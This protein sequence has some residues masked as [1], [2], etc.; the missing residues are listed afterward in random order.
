LRRSLL[1]LLILVASFVIAQDASDAPTCRIS[2][3]V[4]DSL[5]EQPLAGS[6]VTLRG[7]TQSSGSNW[8]SL[9]V[10]ADAEGHFA[11]DSL[12]PGRY[13]ITAFHTGYVNMGPGRA[14]AR[15]RAANLT[16]PGQSIDD[17]AVA[18]TP[19]G[20]ISGRLTN[21][22]NKALNQ[23]TVQVLRHEYISGHID[24]GEVSS[25]QTSKS[26]EYRIASLSPGRYFLR[27]L[28][29]DP[30]PQK[31]GSDDAYVP[32]YYPGT[33]DQSQAVALT[34]RPGEELGGMDM[35]LTP[36]H[37][38][39]VKGVVLDAAAKTPYSDGEVNL[40]PKEGAIFPSPYHATTDAKGRFAIPGVPAGEYIATAQIE[41]EGSQAT[42]KFGQKPVR[43]GDAALDGIEI[44]VAR[45]V[46][47]SGHIRVEGKTVVDLTQ[48]TG[49]IDTTENWA[50]EFGGEIDEAHI[51]SD[52]SFVFYDVPEGAY[53]I[54]F[55][56]VPPGT[57]VKSSAGSEA[58]EDASIG[59][60]PGLPVRS[61]DFALSANAASITGTALT[62][63][64]PA[65]G[66]IILL[67]PSPDRR[68]IY[69]FY[70][71]VVADSQGKFSLP[72]LVP[73][74]YKIFA[75]EDL[76]RGSMMDPD[77][78]SEFE[79]AGKDLTLKEGDTPTVQLDVIPS[80]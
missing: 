72:S 58:V 65:P 10:T 12:T 47:V 74:D 75:F 15:P 29:L 20:A 27:F 6:E 45:G 42:K 31:P 16:T 44:L 55:S 18:L 60:A 25:S 80:E 38:S 21:P 14:G 79:T 71:R 19:G 9:S 52:G 69:H 46:E 49:S 73:G 56:A 32:A 24:L 28:Y 54:S 13:I 36:R 67:V 33:S 40:I 70:K 77:F 64:Q 59:V 4:I 43:V 35:T 63:Q 30:Q 11:F 48:I 53:R 37:T 39:T 51:R 76:R 23:V 34:I 2:G 8:K 1:A 62:D 3:T 26:G 50:R 61:L 68:S 7:P 22:S 41:G 17:F 5:S 57:Y 78:L 66:A